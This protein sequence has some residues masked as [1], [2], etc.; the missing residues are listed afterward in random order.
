MAEKL[1]SKIAWINAAGVNIGVRMWVEKFREGS[2][3]F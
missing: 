1:D 2:L 3:R